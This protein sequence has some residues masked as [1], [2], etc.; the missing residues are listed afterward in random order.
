MYNEAVATKVTLKNIAERLNVSKVTISKAI[1]NQPGVSER[2]RQ[3]ILRVANELGYAVPTKNRFR[4]FGVLIRAHHYVG[5][6]A[7]SFYQYIVYH[8]ERLCHDHDIKLFLRIVSEQDERDANLPDFVEEKGVDGVF[9]VGEF[10]EAFLALVTSY[11]IPTVAVD[12]A[13]ST[14]PVDHVVVDNFCAAYKMCTYL[15]KAG[16][17]EIGFVGDYHHSSSIADRFFGYLKGLCLNDLPYNEE[18]HI[19]ANL[20]DVCFADR[21]SGIR[22]PDPLPSAFLCHNDQAAHRFMLLLRTEGIDVPERLSVAAFDNSE[23]TKKHGFLTTVSI[24]KD[25]MAARAFDLLRRRIVTSASTVNKVVLDTK[26]VERG[27]VLSHSPAADE[28]TPAEF[29]T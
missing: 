17:R 15:I 5:V 2:L 28:G 10:D 3:E 21:T 13:K 11:A 14:M 18:W 26:I 19:R 24:D 27:S 12:F 1:N 22:L 8:I 4:Q 7:D 25:E 29:T 6:G 23:Y 16:H 20:D 9:L